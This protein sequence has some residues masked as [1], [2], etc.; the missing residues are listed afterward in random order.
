MMLGELKPILAALVLP[1]AG[2]LLLVLL[3]LLLAAV[4]RRRGGALLA[5]GGLGG[6][7]LLSCHGA[8]VLLSSLLL[9]AV[10]PLQPAQLQDVQAIVVLGG[11]VVREAPEY[12]RAEPNAATLARLRYGAL[13]ARRSGKPLAFAGGV[14]WASVDAGIA[15]EVQTAQR[16][17]EQEWQLVPRWLDDRSRD[18]EENAQRMRQLLAPAGIGRIAL[19]THAWH[20]PRSLREFE[21]A[22]FQVVPAATGFAAPQVRPLLE[23]LPSAEGLSLSRNVLREALALAWG[24]LRTRREHAGLP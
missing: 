10:A 5:V 22:G 6:A 1:P 11:G 8:A 19:V 7:W 24:R 3:G 13:L 18:T 21:R 16:V 15:P 20:M 17:L 12:G 4:G 14:G 9:P 23:W 2:P